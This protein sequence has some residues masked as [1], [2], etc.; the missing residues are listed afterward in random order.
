MHNQAI[1]WLRSQKK[2]DRATEPEQHIGDAQNPEESFSIE[3]RKLLLHKALNAL[4]AEQREVICLKGFHDFSY[5]EIGEIMGLEKA[6]VA[7]RLHRPD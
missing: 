5:L 4:G 7:T 2:F 6:A 3:Q 1:D